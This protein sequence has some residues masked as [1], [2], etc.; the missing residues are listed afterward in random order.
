MNIFDYMDIQCY[1]WPRKQERGIAMSRQSR[2]NE[3]VGGFHQPSTGGHPAGSI[4]N[5]QVWGPGGNQVGSIENV[6]RNGGI[7][8]DLYDPNGK[9]VTNL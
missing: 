3:V 1:R 4:G 5:Q 8:L 7:G 6:P 2:E 9:K